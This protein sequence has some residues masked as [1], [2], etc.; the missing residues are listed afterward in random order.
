M[1]QAEFNIPKLQNVA[2]LNPQQGLILTPILIK[3]S[4]VIEELL[5]GSLPWEILKDVR[6]LKDVIIM[7]VMKYD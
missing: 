1:F 7:W 5:S 3:V 2:K 6:Y 4:L